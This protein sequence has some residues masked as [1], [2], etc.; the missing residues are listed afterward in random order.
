MVVEVA[1]T[2]RHRLH[3][4]CMP[5][6]PLQAVQVST[7]PFKNIITHCEHSG[8]TWIIFILKS[9]GLFCT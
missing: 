5:V 8:K 1:E 9:H 7:L 4:L 6:S 3:T 2:G